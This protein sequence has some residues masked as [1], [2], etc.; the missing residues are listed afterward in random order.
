[1]HVR[2][3]EPELAD[4]FRKDPADEAFLGELNAALADFEDRSYGDL[5]EELPTLHVIGAPRS[6]T[7]LLYQVL[8]SAMDVGYVNNLVAAFWR[9]PVTGLR[10]ARKLGL[11][12]LESSFDSAFGRTTGVAEPHEFGYFWNHHLR[13]PDLAQ[14]GPDH[15]ASI[16]WERLSRVI[17]N[18]AAALGRPMSFKPMLL[19][20]HLETMVRHMPRTC[21]VWIRRDRRT[22]ALSLLKMRRELLGDERGW[23]SLRPD[24][25]LGDEPPWRQVAAQVVLVEQTIERAL[26]RL[27]PKH[28]LALHYDELCEDPMGAVE[29]TR[30]LMGGLGHAPRVAVDALPPFTPKRNEA[31]EAEFGDRVE[32]ALEHYERL[33]EAAPRDDTSRGGTG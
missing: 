1:M 21:Y 30:D 8:A 23:A 14:R 19:T 29:R 15:D 22:T 28:G 6:G 32:A 13:Y 31:L 12:R 18:M 33:Y 4:A 3:N 24:A 11:E 9:A 26:D 5:P 20:W 7:T 2:P 27:G 17:V 10:L 25:P 16:D